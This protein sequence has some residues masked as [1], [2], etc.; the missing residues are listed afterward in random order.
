MTFLNLF[1]LFGAAAAA[2]PLVIHLLNR[3]KYEIVDWGAMHLLEAVIEENNRRIKIY[4]LLLLVIRC[5]IPIV[6]A[7]CLARPLMNQFAFGGG[8]GSRA[9]LLVVDDSLSM[10]RRD[11]QE[12]SRFDRA[13]VVGDQLAE[14][15]GAEDSITK[16][17]AGSQVFSVPL[18][19]DFDPIAALNGALDRAENERDRG[20]EIVVVSDFQEKDW[21]GISEASLT[22]LASRQKAI[23]NA[24]SI[25][26]LPVDAISSK[27]PSGSPSEVGNVRIERMQVDPERWTPGSSATVRVWMQNVGETEQRGLLVEFQVDKQ[28]VA[29]QAVDIPAKGTREI[30]FDYDVAKAAEDAESAQR[31]E[32]LLT[33]RGVWEDDS[34][35]DHV[36]ST[37][38]SVSQPIRAAV[39]VDAGLAPV[40]A[41]AK[42]TEEEPGK[43]LIVAL[44]PFSFADTSLGWSDSIL[45]TKLDKNNFRL[46]ELDTMDVLVLVDPGTMNSDI[47]D[48]VTEFVRG[49]GGLLIFAG[50]RMASQLDQINETLGSKESPIVAGR[51][52]PSGSADSDGAAA[53]SYRTTIRSGRRFEHPT[54]ALFND[55]SNGN[56]SDAAINEWVKIVDLDE[57]TQVV[58]A[59]ETG[60][61]YAIE[62]SLGKGTILFCSTTAGTTWNNLPLRPVYLPLMQRWVEYLAFKDR[63]VNEDSAGIPASK[64]VVGEVNEGDAPLFGPDGEKINFELQTLD[65]DGER[66]TRVS[67]KE[68]RATGAY[69]LRRP[70]QPSLW[71][72]AD[73]SEDEWDSP[74]SGEDS[75]KEFAQRAGFNVAGSLDDYFEMRSE[76]TTGIEIWRWVWWAVL[77]LMV[78]E[79]GLVWLLARGA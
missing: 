63:P 71:Y 15:L 72:V 2:I 51:L 12:T 9:T 3:S 55:V 20:F 8:G 11:G 29:S 37:V 38:V 32:H 40:D 57:A 58:A 69:E 59:L 60:D 35:L 64:L 66:L 46:D 50:P 25:T 6:L 62:S 27:V 74:S 10:S 49:G 5:L 31:V 70:E 36:R 39:V 73:A 19:G 13:G 78:F 75:L 52:V 45:A 44:S 48:R 26:L 77:A 4:E 14:Q 54:M 76:R 24:P 17:S 41:N 30:I 22:A 43:F 7:L 68:T 16:L 53:D 18:A 56:L 79:R 65:E 23:P 47:V 28:T 61:P 21:A 42:E 67:W 1:M 33:I 34:P